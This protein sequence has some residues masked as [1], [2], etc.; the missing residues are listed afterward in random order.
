[1]VTNDNN[2]GMYMALNLAAAG[3]GLPYHELGLVQPDPAPTAALP[4]THQLLRSELEQ[5]PADSATGPV[6]R[7]ALR[8]L[9]TADVAV[10]A[11]NAQLAEAE[12]RRIKELLDD[13]LQMDTPRWSA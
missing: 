10:L 3:L 13:I 8:H 12:L 7:V 1:M 9:D 4:R 6:R 11:G 2:T 5:L